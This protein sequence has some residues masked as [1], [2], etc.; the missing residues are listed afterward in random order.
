MVHPLYTLWMWWVHYNTVTYLAAS[1][2]LFLMQTRLS[3]QMA[4]RAM[5]EL[6]PLN[7]PTYFMTLQSC[8]FTAFN[9]VDIHSVENANCSFS[10]FFHKN[11]HFFLK[12]NIYNQKN[13]RFLNSISWFESRSRFVFLR[14]LKGWVDID[15]QFKITIVYLILY[16][17][18][19]SADDR[20][21][22]KH[23][24]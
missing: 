23:I 20:S 10:D 15:N 16:I 7:T 2:R 22:I 5:G 8:L 24:L 9:F 14:F 12:L 13:F 4:N 19:G 1:S 18:Q 6:R 11:L 17:Q 3:P 21:K